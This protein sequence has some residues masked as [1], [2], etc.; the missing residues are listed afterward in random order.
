[1]R[2]IALCPSMT[3]ITFR[4]MLPISQA[5]T[6]SST[7]RGLVFEE[8][9]QWQYRFKDIVDLDCGQ[10]VFTIEHEVRSM[11]HPMFARPLVNRDPDNSIRTFAAGH[12]EFRW[13]SV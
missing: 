8:S 10:V 9:S 6:R 12:E 5:R 7:K 1:M 3:A 2:L 11:T 13:A 4:S